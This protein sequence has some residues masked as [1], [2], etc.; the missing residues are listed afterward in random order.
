M[1]KLILI[2]TGLLTLANV[3]VFG[4]ESTFTQRLKAIQ[5]QTATNIPLTRFNLDFPGGTPRDL[6]KAIEKAMSK[7]LNAIISDEDDNAVNIPALKMNDVNVEQLFNALAT[8]SY[9]PVTIIQ[10][11]RSTVE[12]SRGYGFHAD[13]P[14]TDS[15][16]WYFRVDKPSSETLPPA[17]EILRFYSLEPYLNRG[18]SVD[19]VTTA[20]QTGWKMAGLKPQPELNYHKETKMLIAYGEANKLSVIENVLQTLP[21]LSANQSDFDAMRN[22]ISQLQYQMAHLTNKFVTISEQEKSGK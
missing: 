19:D 5:T 15:S 16:I 1:K 20:I 4:Q 7:P 21:R 6:V 14:I 3:P 13:N 8:A 9:K 22:Q 18:F 12:S 2:A 10:P 11:G 17:Q